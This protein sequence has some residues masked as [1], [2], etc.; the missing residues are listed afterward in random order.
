MSWLSI[1][2][3]TILQSSPTACE[4]GTI[5]LQC[6]VLFNG[7]TVPG[8]WRK[9]GIPIDNNSTLSNHFIIPFNSVGQGVLGLIITDVSIADN[10]TELSCIFTG[11]D[12]AS[13]TIQVVGMF[14][15]FTCYM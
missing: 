4:G 8:T 14:G 2:A 1:V 7:A 10:G 3:V 11:L 12:P 15:L 5:T 6:L 9:D 13:V